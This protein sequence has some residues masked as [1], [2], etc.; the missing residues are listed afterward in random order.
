MPE[1]AH[2]EIDPFVSCCVAIDWKKELEETLA[3]RVVICID[4]C[5]EGTEQDS[6][7]LT[8]VRGWATRKVDRVLRKK[9]AYVYAC[10]PGQLA[11]FVRPEDRVKPGAECGTDR[12]DS[13]SLFSRAVRDVFAARHGFSRPWRFPQG[14]PGPYRRAASRVR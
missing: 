1:D 12:G 5:R 3:E 7:A 8:N 2:V 4:A 14:G 11:L 9:V 10:S 13:F 6:M